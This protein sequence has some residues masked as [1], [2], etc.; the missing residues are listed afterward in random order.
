MRKIQL[1][2][3]GNDGKWIYFNAGETPDAPLGIDEN[4]ITEYCGYRDVDGGL[5]YEGDEVK[6]TI[7]AG[8]GKTREIRFIVWH[9]DVI[10]VHEKNEAANGFRMTGYDFHVTGNIFQR[11][12]VTLEGNKQ[13]SQI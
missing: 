12:P 3:L 9:E 7:K 6:S 4:T 11:K 8:R 10:D 2:A 13:N 1:R 5:I